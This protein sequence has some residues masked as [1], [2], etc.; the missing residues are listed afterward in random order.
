[1]L[2]WAQN[3]W[4]QS[5]TDVSPSC[6][7]MTVPASTS[8]PSS[9][10]WLSTRTELDSLPVVPENRI[11][12]P[13]AVAVVLA[14]EGVL[15]MRCGTTHLS[16]DFSSPTYRITLDLPGMMAPRPASGR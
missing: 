15:P 2:C 6:T 12:S 4:R 13:A 14:S 8:V 10:D 3:V 5:V 11:S 1:M 7:V 16:V 9:M